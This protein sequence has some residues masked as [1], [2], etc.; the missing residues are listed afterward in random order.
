MCQT[1]IIKME[2]VF[3][4][5]VAAFSLAVLLFFVL[6]CIQ[7]FKIFYRRGRLSLLITLWNILISPFGQVKFRHFFLADIL[8]SM[9]QPLRDLGYIG[10]FF[11]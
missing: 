7:P 11:F 10:C 3:E 2:I 4:K 5:T 6:I 1:F 9:T 8:T